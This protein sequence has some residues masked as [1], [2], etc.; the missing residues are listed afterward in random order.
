MTQVKHTP[1]PWR[2]RK[3]VHSHKMRV[4]SSRDGHANYGVKPGDKIVADVDLASNAYLIAAAP[5]L[6]EALEDAMDA[7]ETH[8]KSGDSM[9]GCWESDAR[10]AIAKAKGKAV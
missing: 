6:L 1:G 9:Q 4:W 8:C 3:R 5:D 7:W 2:A 10:A